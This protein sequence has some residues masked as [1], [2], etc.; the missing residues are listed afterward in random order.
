VKFKA[1]YI[2]EERIQLTAPG[3]GLI[4]DY[5]NGSIYVSVK[6]LIKL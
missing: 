1:K 4:K 2:N 3:F 6:D 5:G